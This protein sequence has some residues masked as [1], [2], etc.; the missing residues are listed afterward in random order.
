MKKNLFFVVF[1]FAFTLILTSSCSKCYNCS[2]EVEIDTGNGNTE[3]ETVNEDFCTASQ[4]ELQ[5]K[6][7]DGYKCN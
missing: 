7:N 4:D 3:K 1:I 2:Y 5:Q 6:E